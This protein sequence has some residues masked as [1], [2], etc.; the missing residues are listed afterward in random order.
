LA[1]ALSRAVVITPAM[2]DRIPIITKI[3]TTSHRVL[4]P[5]SVAASGLPP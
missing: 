4:T 1:P 2:V 3:L 5:A